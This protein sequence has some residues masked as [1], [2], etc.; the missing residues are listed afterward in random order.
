MAQLAFKRVFSP[1]LLPVALTLIALGL[2][3]C[4]RRGSLEAPESAGAGAVSQTSANRLS[5][6]PARS[7]ARQDASSRDPLSQ[8]GRGA[9]ID[10]DE[11]PIPAPNRP[12]IL[13]S[14]L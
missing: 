10:D 13:D 9:Q 4:G 6:T 2:S 11:A 5:P 1:A 8:T 12:F 14:I 7:S 3:G